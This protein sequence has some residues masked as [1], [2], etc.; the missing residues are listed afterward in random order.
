MFQRL[1]DWS[2]IEVQLFSNTGLFPSVQQSG[3]STRIPTPSPCQSC[4]PF[5]SPQA[6][7]SRPCAVQQAPISSLFSHVSPPTV[8]TR[9]VLYIWDYFC[10]ANNFIYTIFLGFPGSVVKNPPANARHMGS[11]PGWERAPGV[12]NCNSFQYSSLENSVDSSWGLQ[13]VGH[14]WHA[15][16]PFFIDSTSKWRYIFLFLTD[17]SLYDNL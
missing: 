13:R 1:T 6:A 2:R 7:G 15:R 16:I 11:I 8:L 9:F 12:E 10:F 17:F 3:S 4:F 5:R 14:D